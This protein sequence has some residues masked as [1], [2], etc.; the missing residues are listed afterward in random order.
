MQSLFLT[1]SLRDNERDHEVASPAAWPDS[2]LSVSKKRGPPVF[3]PAALVDPVFVLSNEAPDLSRQRAEPGCVP[4]ATEE[5]PAGPPRATVDGTKVDGTKRV[6][7]QQPVC[8]KSALFPLPQSAI[9]LRSQNHI[10]APAMSYFNN[11]KQANF[12]IMTT[13]SIANCNRDVDPSI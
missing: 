3:T 5:A 10:I 12:G 13:Y 2:V 6:D 8:A 11:Y 4:N 9:L 7:L 1:P